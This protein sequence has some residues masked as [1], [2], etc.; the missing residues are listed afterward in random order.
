MP[1]IIEPVCPNCKSDIAMTF[2]TD[3]SVKAVICECAAFGRRTI[4]R[5]GDAYFKPHWWALRVV[6]DAALKTIEQGGP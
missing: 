2:H 5:P 6:K 4:Y 1:A 3:G